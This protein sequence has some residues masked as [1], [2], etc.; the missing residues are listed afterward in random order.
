MHTQHVVEQR[1]ESGGE[2]GHEAEAGGVEATVSSEA[3]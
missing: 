3:A 1:L 2:T